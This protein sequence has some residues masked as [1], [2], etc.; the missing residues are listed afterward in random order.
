MKQPGRIVYYTTKDLTTQYGRT[1]NSENL[2]NGKT[3]VHLLTPD[4]KEIKDA[5]G[6]DVKVLVD[7]KK[8]NIKGFVD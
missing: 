6:N 8:L 5:A 3:V 7:A 2:V 1:Y 4:L